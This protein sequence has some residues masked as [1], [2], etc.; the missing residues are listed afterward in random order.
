M[1]LPQLP[2]LP[3]AQ[4]EA[5]PGLEQTQGGLAH[6]IDPCLLAPR[7][8]IGPPQQQPGID[9]R[10]Q[11]A[12]QAVSMSQVGEFQAE[13]PA[14]VFEIFEHFLNPEAAAPMDIPVSASVW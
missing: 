7:N 2:T 10:Q 14:G 8:D 12:R 9:Q 3:Q 5:Q 4:D 13:A 6:G 1:K 11:Q